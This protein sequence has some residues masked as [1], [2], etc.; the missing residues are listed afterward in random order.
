MD[1]Y[2]RWYTEHDPESWARKKNPP[3]RRVAGDAGRGALGPNGTWRLTTSERK[4]ILLEHIYGVDIDPQAVEVT[5]LNLLLKALEGE[6]DETL[7]RQLTFF[8]E[9]AL[10]DL[11]R[12]IKCGNSLIG[13]DYY[14]A[15]QGRLFDE[16][17]LYRVNPFDWEKEFPEVFSPSGGA[18]RRG[19]PGNAPTEARGRG[20]GGFDVVIGN[21]PYVRQEL[22]GELKAYFQRHYRVYH[23]VADL[24]VYFIERG[25]SLLRPGG[26]FSYI[27]A[28]KW[29]RANY[30]QP[31]RRWLKEQ[32]IEE[33]VDFGDLPVFKA[34]TTYPCI[35][36]IRKG[37]PWNAPTTGA[38][39]FHVAQVE[40]LDFGD[41]DEY[42]R[43]HRYPVNR[44]TLG[45]GG[46]ALVDER[47]E[48]LLAKLRA[49]GVPLGEYVQG[50]IYR[51]ILTG[52]NEAFI[53]DAETRER[54]IAE[55]PKSAEL[56]VPFLMGRDIK[57]Y[58]PPTSD[59]WLIFTRR[60]VDIKRYPA[61]ERHLA[62]FKDRLLPKPKGWKGEWH[63]R[64]P[65]AYKWYEIQD[66]I[67][68]YAEFE[69]PKIIY[70]NISK[71][72]E[73][74]LDEA[75]L[76]TNQ[77]CFIISVRDLYLVGLLNSAIT[78]FM[79]RQILPK[80]RGGF[81][82]PS[83]I[84]FKEFPIRTIDFSDPADR[85]RHERMVEL[86]ERMLALHRRLAAAQTPTEKTL[87]QRQIAATDEQ[88]DRL[89]YELY[90]LT[91]EEIALVEGR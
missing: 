7:T 64:K 27:V 30:G 1:W 51:G 26:L 10:P 40:T 12:N 67:D 88:I 43:R 55:D 45:D 34:A 57:R 59:R 90:N 48:R 53:I 89:V 77:K 29:L 8:H 52:L 13:P 36:R 63:G 25:V 4:R 91:E 32:E 72:P 84:Y 37:V 82:E 73:F 44:A 19:V 5:K 21:P 2:L 47:T 83:Y 78:A 14:A 17:E 3:I 65:G 6:N 66:T 61:I 23:G 20:E 86:V 79:Y 46:W 87:L 68:Y 71:R 31:L 42:V 41:L 15:Q 75:G 74:T 11:G 56:I 33:I 54:L 70:P 35:L 9:R 76:Y 80:L 50:R 38:P 60:G 69:K 39:T 62:Q 22:L 58:A 16:E 28:N 81:Y 18:L 49:A 85:A 24:Y